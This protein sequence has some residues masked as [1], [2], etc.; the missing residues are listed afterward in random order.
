MRCSSVKNR[1]LKAGSKHFGEGELRFFLGFGG[2]TAGP[3][4]R[5]VVFEGLDDGFEAEAE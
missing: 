2:F 5:P 3:G 4:A 1:K